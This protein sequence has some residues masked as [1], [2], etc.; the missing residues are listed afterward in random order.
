MDLAEATQLSRERWP[1]LQF[2]RKEYLALY[3]HHEALVMALQWML[4]ELQEHL[5][6]VNDRVTSLENELRY[7][8]YLEEWVCNDT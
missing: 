8:P 3:A 2:N 4:N 5:V 7:D 6:V 1:L